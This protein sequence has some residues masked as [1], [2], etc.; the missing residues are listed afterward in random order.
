MVRPTINSEKHY[1]QIPINSVPMG[2]LTNENIV[3]VSATP[4]GSAQIGPGTVI[5]AVFIELWILAGSQQPGSFTISVDK[6]S[7]GGTAMTFLEGAQLHDYTNKKNVLYVT[8]GV[9]PDANGNPVPVLRQWYKIPRGK[10]RFGLG[11]SLQLN[12]SANVE[13]MTYCGL[14]VFKAY[15]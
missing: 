13:D 7:S 9:S 2:T 3:F 10:Q 11:D 1:N 8:Q 6:L 4:T 5:K 14:I 12:I 15:T